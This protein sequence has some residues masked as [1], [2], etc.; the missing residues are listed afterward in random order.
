MSDIGQARLH[1][2]PSLAVLV[3]DAVKQNK[4]E[5]RNKDNK[6]VKTR[7]IKEDRNTTHNI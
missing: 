4:E 5:G 2:R 3:W 6:V 7:S 1:T